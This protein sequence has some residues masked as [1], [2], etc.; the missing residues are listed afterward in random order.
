MF[1]ADIMFAAVVNKT[2]DRDGDD[3]DAR[4]AI[5]RVYRRGIAIA[6]KMRL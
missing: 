2:A 5:G 4:T 3:T 1:F 6:R